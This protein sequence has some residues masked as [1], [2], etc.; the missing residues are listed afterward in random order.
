M[1]ERAISQ[2]G[3][4]KTGEEEEIDAG[5]AHGWGDRWNIVSLCNGALRVALANSSRTCGVVRACRALALA[6]GLQNGIR[7]GGPINVVATYS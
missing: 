1:H 3:R 6:T 7:N 5:G 4:G 2:D